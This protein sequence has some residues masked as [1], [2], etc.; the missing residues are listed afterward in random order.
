MAIWNFAKTRFG[1]FLYPMARTK[2]REPCSFF[3]NNFI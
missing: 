1:R 3:S 2:Q